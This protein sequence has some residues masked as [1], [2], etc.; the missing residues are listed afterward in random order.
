MVVTEAGVGALNVGS[1]VALM[2][3]WVV[4]ACMAVVFTEAVTGF[5]TDR[6]Y[7]FACTLFA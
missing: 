5:L 7:G 3:W 1:E 2:L 4:S 6:V